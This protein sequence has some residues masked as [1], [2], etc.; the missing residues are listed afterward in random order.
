MGR[1]DIFT[2]RRFFFNLLEFVFQKPYNYLV[3]DRDNNEFYRKFNKISI[4]SN[5]E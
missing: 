1:N 3:L 2:K 4:T 5:D